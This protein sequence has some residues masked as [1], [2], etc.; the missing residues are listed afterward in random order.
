MDL[1]DYLREAVMRMDEVVLMPTPPP[2]PVADPSMWTPIWGV[3]K[4]AAYIKVSAEVAHDSGFCTCG[5]VCT[6]QSTPLPPVPWPH[7][8]QYFLRRR[9]WAIKRLP[10]YR[11]VHKSE[12]RDP[13][14]DFEYSTDY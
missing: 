12:L 6:Y 14:D 4:P 10:G 7:R 1:Q 2:E 3:E 8:V 9:W 13:D 11:L 5:D